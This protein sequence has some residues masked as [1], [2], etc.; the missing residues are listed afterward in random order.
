MY[1][2]N[3]FGCSAS[4]SA[5]AS[6][7]PGGTPQVTVLSAQSVQLP[8][9]GEF[10]LGDFGDGRCQAA[11]LQFLLLN[12]GLEASYVWEIYLVQERGCP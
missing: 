9:A 12:A 8:A 1:I 7:D 11:S 2:G 4:K 6:G 10:T 5:T 3:V